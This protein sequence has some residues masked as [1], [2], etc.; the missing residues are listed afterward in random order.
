MDR[1][2]ELTDDEINKALEQQAI[3]DVIDYLE[4][5]LEELEEMM[6]DGPLSDELMQEYRDKDKTVNELLD[7]V[8]E[9]DDED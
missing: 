3:W 4:E 8:D 5:R 6:E 7:K 9:F 2:D 1:E